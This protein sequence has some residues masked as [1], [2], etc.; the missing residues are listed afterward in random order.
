MH[1][2]PAIP[3]PDDDPFSP[4]RLRRLAY[5]TGHV[6]WSALLDR[7]E[8]LGWEAAVVGPAGT[9]KSTFLE[10]LS[11]ALQRE[12]FR[13]WRGRFD[14]DAPDR[15]GVRLPLASYSDVSDTVLLVDGC[16]GL[17]RVARYRL[18]HLARRAAGLVV[19]DRSEDAR[20]V[21]SLP[22][23]LRTRSS[24]ALL[25]D[26]LAELLPLGPRPGREAIRRAY[27]RSGGDLGRAL[28]LLGE[29]H[30]RRVR[31]ETVVAVGDEP[32]RARYES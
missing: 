12:G 21:R 5:R 3:G 13:V 23:L 2:H 11:R 30:A 14:T 17:G 31:P 18:D 6:P 16:A 32:R 28:R 1:D 22:V 26:L 25:E 10:G 20:P 19:A 29:K 4:E 7:L 24:P 27:L 8:S 15:W 9:G